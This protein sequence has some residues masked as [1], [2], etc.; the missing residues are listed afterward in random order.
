M[1]RLRQKKSMKALLILFCFS[2][3]LYWGCKKIDTVINLETPPILKIP[4]NFFVTPPNTS[5]L[6]KRIIENIKVRNNNK[7]FITNF[8]NE[9]G[10]PVWDKILETTTRHASHGNGGS[11]FGGNGGSSSNNNDTII[12][13]PFVLENGTTINGFFRAT[14]ND[15]ILI[16]YS[17]TKDYKGYTFSNNNSNSQATEFAFLSMK[18]NT[19]VFG[20][21]DYQITDS[22]L[23]SPDTV[24]TKSRTI[25]FE[26][27]VNQ[28]NLF[29]TFCA[30]STVNFSYCGTSSWC[31]TQGG[32]DSPNCSTGQCYPYSQTTTT[33]TTFETPNFPGG[34]GGGGGTGGGGQIP[35]AY[36]CTPVLNPSFT[37][38]QNSGGN[39][40]LPGDPL[41]PCPSPGSGWIPTPPITDPISPVNDSIP[42]I[43][44]RACNHQADSVFNW[45]LQNNNREQ[46]FILV[47]KNGLIYPKNFQ[48]G[49]QNG[50]KA[51]VNYTLAEG[52]QLVAY[53]HTHP[54]PTPQERSSF[55]AD[56]FI[57]LTKNRN[58]PGYTAI[59]ECGNVRYAFVI[60]DLSKL[61]IFTSTRRNNVLEEGWVNAI[62]SQPNIYS[63]GPQAC[64]NGIVQY[65]GSAS[66]CGVGFYK[67]TPPDKNNFVKLNP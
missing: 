34:G 19:A 3:I 20:V 57:E 33:C 7:E 60:E 26:P 62:Y 64:I 11:S 42:R 40:V 30:T 58:I 15:S 48:P 61:N 41:P 47:K 2:I 6:V 27:E 36:P 35:P 39:S 1:Q 23:F 18:L 24:T 17:L 21:T 49:S 13:I 22:R 66:V 37:G 10:Y 65:L 31:N 55:S 14:I 63:N 5:K 43:L 8:A 44:S 32:C 53:F 38:G 59:L 28:N 52:E 50:A 4:E 46:S 51:R 25:H 9:F 67:S 56:D 16:N 45:G 29:T 12:L 54:L